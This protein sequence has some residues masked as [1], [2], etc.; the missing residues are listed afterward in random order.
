MKLDDALKLEQAI[1][2]KDG[3]YEQI[4]TEIKRQ[5]YTYRDLQAEHRQLCEELEKVEALI[6]SPTAPK[7]DG[8]PHGSSG[9]SSPVEILA[10]KHLTL[11]DLYRK[12]VDR[13]MAEQLRIEEM[14][15]G[16][17][18]TERRLAR[19]R[20]IDGM[21]WE[22]VCTR[23]SYSWRQTHRIHGRIIDKLTTAEIERRK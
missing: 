13:L 9:P 7:M 6:T 16:L 2:G 18:P 3:K 8:M 20:Y 22:E 17:E 10:V 14:I 21:T 5:L 12:Q 23:M 4:R 15:D 1:D 11:Q 19:F